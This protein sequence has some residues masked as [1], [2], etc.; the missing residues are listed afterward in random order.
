MSFGKENYRLHEV[1][2]SKLKGYNWWPSVI[3]E[4]PDKNRAKG[5][6]LFRVN[7]IG[8]AYHS[9]LKGNKILPFDIS[10][11]PSNTKN[12]K[13][14]KSYDY[15]DQILKHE[16]SVEDHLDDMLYTNSNINSKSNNKLLGKK[17]NP[18]YSHGKI[19]NHASS[20]PNNQSNKKKA[21][22]KNKKIIED[23]TYEKYY[24]INDHNSSRKRTNSNIIYKD[25]NE[26]YYNKINNDC[27]FKF[28]SITNCEEAYYINS[29]ENG[30][31]II[32]TNSLYLEKY[33]QYA[34]DTK[35]D[36]SNFKIEVYVKCYLNT[37]NLE[38]FRELQQKELEE[39][40]RKNLLE[41]EISHKSSPSS[42]IHESHL[43]NHEYNNSP[44]LTEERK[45]GKSNFYVNL[46]FTDKDSQNKATFDPQLKYSKKNQENKD[47]LEYND[48]SCKSVYA[49]N[50]N[51][52]EYSKCNKS[53]SNDLNDMSK[54]NSNIQLFD[55][56]KNIAEPYKNNTNT[57]KIISKG[58]QTL[59]Q[60][61]NNETSQLNLTGKEEENKDNSLSNEIN[62]IEEI[63]EAKNPNLFD[64]NQRNIMNQIKNRF[65]KYSVTNIDNLKKV[66]SK[67]PAKS[68][69]SVEDLNK[70]IF[71]FQ[72]IKSE[73]D[74]DIINNED[75]VEISF[76]VD[77]IK[78][79]LE[80]L[81]SPLLNAEIQ[82]PQIENLN[83]LEENPELSIN[84]NIKVGE[85]KKKK[86]ERKE[87][88]DKKE[89]K[90]KREKRDTSLKKNVEAKQGKDS[91]NKK[92]KTEE[93][94][95][96]NIKIS[97]EINKIT[98]IYN[99]IDN[100]NV[101]K[102]N[103]RSKAKVKQK[104]KEVI[105]IKETEDIKENNDLNEYN[106]EINSQSEEESNKVEEPIKEIIKESNGNENKGKELVESNKPEDPQPSENENND[107][108]DKESNNI[109]SDHINN[110]LDS[111]DSRISNTLSKRK[112]TKYITDFS[113]RDENSRFPLLMYDNKKSKRFIDVCIKF[114]IFENEEQ[115][116]QFINNVSIYTKE[117]ILDIEKL[118]LASNTM[119]KFIKHKIV[120]IENE[121]RKFFVS[122]LIFKIYFF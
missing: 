19:A 88:K 74:N 77:E 117:T 93:D 42:K 102:A 75:N 94:I 55:V 66:I 45:N 114:S 72:T 101:K 54:Y 13:L 121:Y 47:N 9:F 21:N 104:Q 5:K 67:E 60:I 87:K 95:L 10:K 2:L 52:S 17:R 70:L 103:S 79:K 97:K 112:E 107:D 91:R 35:C 53:N 22:T 23:D 118:N 62:L 92:S 7:F 73:K 33:L 6:D 78:E 96:K 69:F 68:L 4:L 59:S 20:H 98:D 32:E 89:K 18:S 120:Y 29:L 49:S 11:R 56:F 58:A 86:R 36:E 113:Q 82:K 84:E 1:V 63:S 61:N 110:N 43:S 108:Y 57:Y 27:A 16:L 34:S 39:D 109:K 76:D 38:H 65:T 37:S 119:G 46:N 99:F 26:E 41:E 71:L 51:N 15:A 31:S 50:S 111:F 106:A 105:E 25:E 116:L 122:K 85:E 90:T 12:S 83:L 115:I 14:A 100:I 40:L 44:S 81:K 8:D 48:V 3:T 30:E 28:K 24:S 64:N 80:D